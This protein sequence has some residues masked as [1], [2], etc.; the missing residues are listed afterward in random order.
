MTILTLQLKRQFFDQI[1]SGKKTEEYREIRPGN[2]ARYCYYEKDQIY[3]KPID[4]I[5]FVTGQ[6]KG[7]RP[8]II[9]DVVKSEIGLIVD[10]N[11]KEIIYFEND[12][13]C[14]AAEV[15][16]TLGKVTFNSENQS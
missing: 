9:V 8:F 12:V 2:E 15:I 3:P 1:V 7:T 10:E 13:E 6:Y 5:K 14:V 16:Y 4:Q 11:D